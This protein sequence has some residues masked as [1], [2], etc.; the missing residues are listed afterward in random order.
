[1]STNSIKTMSVV[2][3]ASI[4]GKPKEYVYGMIQAKV[5]DFG[6]YYLKEGKTRGTYLIPVGRFA[7]YLGYPICEVE[8]A[9]VKVRREAAQ[10]KAASKLQKSR[11]R[12]VSG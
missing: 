7:Q 6:T 3:A 8:S 5:V 9:L 1:M 11:M 4:L 12:I 2:E 10:R